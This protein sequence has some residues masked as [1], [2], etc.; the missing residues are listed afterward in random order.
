[1]K[2]FSSFTI[3]LL[4]LLSVLLSPGCNRIFEEHIK[5]FPNYGWNKERVLEYSFE[6]DDTSKSYSLILAFRHI[7]GFTFQSF[8]VHVE[9][10]SGKD[11]LHSQTHELQVFDENNEL[12]SDCAV[13]YCDL[14][15]TI[16]SDLQF[17]NQGVYKVSVQ[18]VSQYS[19]LPYTMEVGVAVE[20]ND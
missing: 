15:Q 18:Q 4:L 19:D 6:I 17:P 9:L 12:L 8:P 5:D 13:D 11:I 10:K 16:L 1:M 20:I 3:S 14:E 2:S 7:F